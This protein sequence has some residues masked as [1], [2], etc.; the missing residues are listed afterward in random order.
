VRRDAPGLRAG[1]VLALV[2][3]ACA[4]GCGGVS[5]LAVEP[6]DVAAGGEIVLRGAGFAKGMVARLAPSSAVSSSSS[7]GIVTL[8]VD[9]VGPARATARVPAATPPG[10]WDVVVEL[11]GR[12]DRLVDALRVQD[13]ALEVYFLDVG[14]GDASLIVGPDGSALLFD[15]GNRDAG[16]DV[17]AA[18]RARTGGR[19][20]AVAVSHT[21]ADHLG[22]VQDPHLSAG[23]RQRERG[24]QAGEPCADDN[25][26]AHGVSRLS[27]R[28][29]A[30]T[31]AGRAGVP[32]W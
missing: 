21:D 3:A 25:D 2:A 8:V 32:C 15:G 31:G 16:P 18:L 20:D 26:V 7:A 10:R 24:R 9:D 13:G 14:Q 19:L 30:S 22:G 6:E 28:R 12:E 29:S 5:L 1:L 11:D 27:A 23:A 4:A 17:V